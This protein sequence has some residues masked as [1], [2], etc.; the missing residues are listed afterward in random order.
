M[1]NGQLFIA[2]LTEQQSLSPAMS[3]YKGWTSTLIKDPEVKLY[4]HFVVYAL[5]PMN[6][7]SKAF[8]THASRI[9]TLQSDVRRLLNSFISNF[10]EPGQQR[11]ALLLTS[12]SNLTSSVMMSWV[13]VHP[14]VHCCVAILRS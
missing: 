7:F 12:L 4:C 10:I 14:P 11:I 8:Q 3:D 1:S 9:G 2:I 5:K 13:L 6:I